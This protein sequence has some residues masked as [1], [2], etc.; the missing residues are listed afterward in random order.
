LDFFKVEHHQIKERISWKASSKIGIKETTS[1]ETISISE[2]N[3]LNIHL[4]LL[5]STVIVLTF[6]SAFWVAVPISASFVIYPSFAPYF[7]PSLPTVAGTRASYSY[8]QQ[9]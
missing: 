5:C 8:R 2:Y 3:V 1:K 7:A 9:V 4:I 6:S